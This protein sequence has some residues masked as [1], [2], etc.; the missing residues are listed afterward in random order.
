MLGAPASLID[1]GCAEGAL[2]NWAL[3]SGIEAMG[4][5]L[6]VPEG[7]PYL[8]RA[9]LREPV[10][11]KVRSEWVLCWEVAEHLPETAAETLVAT[12]V[13][14]MLPTGRVLFTAAG[15][16]QRGPGHIHC[17]EPAFW[18]ALF[19]G[20]G[21]TYADGLSKQLRSRWA[22]CAPKTPWYGRN[23][24]IFWRVA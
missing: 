20:Y 6:A 1:V 5:D 18:Q 13:R 23:C 12:L 22:H 10:D 21:V 2:V 9:D 24:Q 16:G 11:L 14:H 8:V 17:A 7:V 3:A 15:P 19:H 4:I